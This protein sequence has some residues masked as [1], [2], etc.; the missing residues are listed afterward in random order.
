[1]IKTHKD[2]YTLQ[3]L[4]SIA[5]INYPETRRDDRLLTVCIYKLI[6]VDTT[7]A[8]EDLMTNKD[9]PS[10]E[11]IGRCRRKLQ[12][13]H[14]DLRP[15]A[16]DQQLRMNMQAEYRCYVKDEDPPCVLN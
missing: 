14:P 15:P 12:E 6:G 11:S 16:E 5:L 3:T 1:M 13:D 4:V 9:L 8:F 10:L 7:G 2:L